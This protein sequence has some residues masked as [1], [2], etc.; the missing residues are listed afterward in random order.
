MR[1]CGHD[2]SRRVKTH[3]VPFC[4]LGHVALVVHQ[5]PDTSHSDLEQQQPRV[6]PLSTFSHGSPPT[7]NNYLYYNYNNNKL[8][9][10]TADDELAAASACRITN[11]GVSDNPLHLG[12][13]NT[14]QYSADLLNESANTMATS[15]QPLKYIYNPAPPLP[16]VVHH[17]QH[18]MLHH[19]SS[20][21]APQTISCTASESGSTT[22][23]SHS[24]ASSAAYG[25]APHPG[26][27][28]RLSGTEV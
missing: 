4:S 23:S 18:H 6:R 11:S 8:N 22:S 25:T 3:D 27:F 5:T 7:R 12:Q 2:N 1:I 16:I 19:Q 26:K 17:S 9:Y 24:Q 10:L 15:G 14:S 13:L 28:K 20:T 21:P